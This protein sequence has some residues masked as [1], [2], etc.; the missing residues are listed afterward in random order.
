MD[1]LGEKIKKVFDDEK[2]DILIG[3]EKG[4][5]P[6][7]GTPCI[8][9]SA[10]DADKL[11]FDIT[12]YN[13]L[14]KYLIDEKKR[15]GD[16]PHKVGI[17]AKGCDA[18]AVAQLVVEGQF[19]KENL[20]I[21]GVPCEGVIDPGK[22]RAKLA[23]REITDSEIKGDKIKLIGDG[24]ELE[25]PKNELLSDSCLTCKYPNAPQYDHLIGEPA[26]PLGIKGEYEA[27]DEFESKPPDERW[28]YFEREL[29][30]CI[31]CYACRNACPVC[32][33]NECFV[34][35]STPQWTGKGNDVSD[36][37]IFHIVRVLH[38]AGRCV[39]CGACA[40]ACPLNINIRLLGKRVEKEILERFDYTAGLDF[41]TQPALAAYDENDKEEFIM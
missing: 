12:C 31:R 5:L 18:R 19:N 7:R 21:I 23:G 16:E 30:R 27:V 13:N 29:S 6:L 11:I 3:F 20:V 33:C 14:A 41:E 17:V 4:T 32:Y 10:D 36:T 1:K 8:I 37:V 22:L 26:K 39:D 35:C 34:D 28:A 24:F 2:L 9:E 40:A 38:T 25:V 15:K